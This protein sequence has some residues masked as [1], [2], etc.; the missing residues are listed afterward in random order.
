MSQRSHK[1]RAQ[2]REELIAAAL[3][4]IAE[5]GVDGLTT[6]DLARRVGLVPSALYRHF[7][8]MAALLDAVVEAIFDRLGGLVAQAQA[9]TDSG[10]DCLQALFCA[11]LA[12]IRQHPGIPM[13][14]FSR[15]G[16]G[17]TPTR[18]AR[19]LAGIQGLRR[20]V[21]DMLRRAA[22]SGEIDSGT[23]IEAAAVLYLGLVQPAALLQMLH[24]R[25]WDIE[26]HAEALWPCFRRALGAREATA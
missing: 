19:V 26:H 24:D 23:D 7:S 9:E 13:L 12:M 21:A 5:H 4:I 17:G 2:R 1:P 15:E 25:S 16:C 18:Q 22:A 11:H 10:L 20:Q 3:E 8:D 6:Q 14:I